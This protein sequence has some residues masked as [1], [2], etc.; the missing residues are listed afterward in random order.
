[1]R[2]IL[3]C[4]ALLLTACSGWK[5]VNPSARGN[6]WTVRELGPAPTYPQGIVGPD[7]PRFRAW[8]S[9][10][11]AYAYYVFVYARNLN[12]YAKVHG[13]RP[14][15]AAPICEKFDMWVVHPIPER[16]TLDERSRRPEDITRDLALQLKRILVNY[17][18][19]RK[20]FQR[21]YENHVETCLN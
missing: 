21:A 16:I 14:P 3:I 10:V 1:M 8:V 5:P 4:L 11:N 20:S 17:R 13:W 2:V 7:D 18:E 9:D 15:Q 6:E 19:D 12:D